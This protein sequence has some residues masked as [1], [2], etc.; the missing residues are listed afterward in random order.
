MTSFKLCIPG[1]GTRT[2]RD[3]IKFPCPPTV[4]YYLSA[5]VRNTQKNHVIQELEKKLTCMDHF[6]TEIHLFTW[7]DTG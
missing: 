3:S 4:K 5:L 7:W 1:V 6:H 2:R